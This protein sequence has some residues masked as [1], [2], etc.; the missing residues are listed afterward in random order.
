MHAVDVQLECIPAVELLLAELAGY[1]VVLVVGFL[2]SD[3]IWSG[4]EN[5]I[6]VLALVIL[7]AKM[8]TIDVVL[9]ISRAGE[10]LSTN[11]TRGY[12]I[13]WPCNWREWYY[14]D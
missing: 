10:P 12:N 13:A 7:E 4:P 1:G 2:V 3:A 8:D 11:L 9:N 14:R 5:L 6:A